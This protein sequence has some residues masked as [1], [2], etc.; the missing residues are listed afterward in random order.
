V[1]VGVDNG[2]RLDIETWVIGKVST[3]RG[4]EKRGVCGGRKEGSVWGKKV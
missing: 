1:A 2:I 4:E 3:K